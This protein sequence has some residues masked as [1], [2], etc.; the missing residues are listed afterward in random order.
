MK[1]QQNNGLITWTLFIFESVLILIYVL[2]FI[3]VSI[4]PVCMYVNQQHQCS[5]VFSLSLS[6][7]FHS[8]HIALFGRAIC[9]FGLVFRLPNRKFVFA[10]FG[11]LNI[12]RT[13]YI[14]RVM[15]ES[16]GEMIETKRKRGRNQV[17]ESKWRNRC[18]ETPDFCFRFTF[19]NLYGP[20]FAL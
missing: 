13:L 14:T 5:V 8:F 10:D 4:V 9:L 7:H 1:R 11:K 15:G 3:D 20:S 2:I 12:I 19:V 17:W 16:V 6:L 18:V